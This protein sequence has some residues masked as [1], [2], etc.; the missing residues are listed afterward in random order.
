[1]GTQAIRFVILAMFEIGKL[2]DQSTNQTL[3]GRTDRHSYR[4]AWT[5]MKIRYAKQVTE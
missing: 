4:D 1:M 5:H 2:T 3:E